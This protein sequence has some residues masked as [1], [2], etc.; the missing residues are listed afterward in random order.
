DAMMA[1]S[2]EQW[3]KEMKGENYDQ[4]WA[5]VQF[6]AHADNGKYQKPF[7]QFMIALSRG[8]QW[9]LAWQE[10]FGSAEG[11]EKQWEAWWTS[12]PTNP[13]P[14]VYSEAAVRM[15]ANYAARAASQKQYFT[16]IDELV[17]A[18]KDKSAKSAPADALPPGLATD[19]VSL[20]TAVQKMG[21]KLEFE[22]PPKGA[23][24]VPL[25]VTGK[26]DDGRTI[27]A[28]TPTRGPRVGQIQVGTVAPKAP[29]TTR[30]AK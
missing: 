3:N 28:T 23:T 16:T 12:Q 21:V 1:L 20:T 2:H 30:K 22:F 15:L 11:F 18:I 19:C 27:R 14:V 8:K 6:L 17:A 13:T 7:T 4:A 26:L 9:K 24:T 5:M 25:A 10:S 29:P